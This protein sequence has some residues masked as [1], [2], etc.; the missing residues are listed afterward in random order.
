MK[1]LKGWMGSSTLL[2][3]FLFPTITTSRQGPDSMVNLKGVFLGKCF[4][5]IVRIKNSA[6]HGKSIDWQKQPP[7]LKYII[8]ETQS[9]PNSLYNLRT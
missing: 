7:S 9:S 6:F 5:F 1:P 4:K 2:H 3:L 8:T